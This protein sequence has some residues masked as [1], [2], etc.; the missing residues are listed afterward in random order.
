MRWCQGEASGTIGLDMIKGA[1]AVLWVVLSV[2]L[3][4][5]CGDAGWRAFVFGKDGEEKDGVVGG[6]DVRLMTV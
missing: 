5:P 4:R 6:P 3:T 1:T 2:S